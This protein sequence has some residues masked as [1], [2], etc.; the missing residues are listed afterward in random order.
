MYFV[1]A[2]QNV[3]EQNKLLQLQEK[4]KIRALYCNRAI[5]LLAMSKIQYLAR[6][7]IKDVKSSLSDDSTHVKGS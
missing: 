6:V 4:W 1:E 3:G 7:E 5:D 2:L